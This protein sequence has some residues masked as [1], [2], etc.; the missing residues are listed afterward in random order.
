M[1]DV[2]E[3]SAA[4]TPSVSGEDHYEIVYEYILNYPQDRESAHIATLPYLA[5]S[6]STVKEESFYEVQSIQHLVWMLHGLQSSDL[7]LPEPKLASGAAAD[8]PDVF[9]GSVNVKGWFPAELFTSKPLHAAAHIGS[10]CAQ[11][12]NKLMTYLMLD[13]H[14]QGN[15][16]RQMAF[17]NPKYDIRRS[18]TL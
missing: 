3:S 7:T 17:K 11:Y 16:V 12:E 5:M 2:D 4:T 1:A 14:P 9:S 10:P 6:W 8:R 15:L 18:C 13:L